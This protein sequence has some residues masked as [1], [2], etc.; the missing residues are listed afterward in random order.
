MPLHKKP[1][2]NEVTGEIEVFVLIRGV[3]RLMGGYEYERDAVVVSQAAWHLGR[4]ASALLDPNKRKGKRAAEY[5][6]DMML[7]A[8]AHGMVITGDHVA[9]VEQI[10]GVSLDMVYEIDDIDRVSFL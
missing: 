6:R 4:I 1:K 5:A 7:S 10:A 3:N 2:Y 8:M 9:R